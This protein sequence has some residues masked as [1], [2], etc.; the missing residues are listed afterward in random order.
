MTKIA[1]DAMIDAA[2]SYAGGGDTMCVCSTQ[3]TTEAEAY[4]TYMLA[5]VAMVGGDFV[6][7]DDVSGRKMTVAAKSGI[8]ITNPGTALHVA[9]VNHS[10]GTIRYITTCTSQVLTAGGTVDVPAW[11]INIADP[12]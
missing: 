4:T 3:P 8:S 2:L 9:L 12:T 5:R 6:N 11:K 10:G 7:A 1:P